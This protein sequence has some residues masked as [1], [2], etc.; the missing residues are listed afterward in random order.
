M[1]EH[2]L[3]VE[4]L[5]KAIKKL[6]E[7]ATSPIALHYGTGPSNTT[8]TKGYKKH[9]SS[10]DFGQ[11]NEVILI[12][13]NKKIAIVEPRVTM[14]TLLEATL[15]YYLAP[16]IL[17]EFKGITVGGAILGG[18][19]ESGSHKLLNM[20]DSFNLYCTVCNVS[21]DIDLGEV[22]LICGEKLVIDVIERESIYN[23][24]KSDK[25]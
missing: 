10:I 20:K 13:C 16:P 7:Q 25:I 14:K 24:G 2:S 19:A 3:K 5:Q 15:P 11:L 18:A 9:C 1:S 8:R 6:S 17:P 23:N 22:C 12:D 4:Q 21:Y